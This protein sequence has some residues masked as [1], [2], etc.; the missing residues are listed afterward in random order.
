MKLDKAVELVTEAE[1]DLASGLARLAGR[2]AADHDV[3]HLGHTLADR[4]REHLSRLAPLASALGASEPDPEAGAP[5]RGPVD[6]LRRVAADAMGRSNLPALGMLLDLRECYLTAQ[7]AE[8]T[9]VVLSQGAKAARHAELEALAASCM[10]EVEGTAK[11]LRTK[12][13]E[14]SPQVLVAG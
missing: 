12:I 7:R 5:E 2:H 6:T 3:Y 10:E 1:E 9:W 8:I 13:K 4:S 14:A 11:W